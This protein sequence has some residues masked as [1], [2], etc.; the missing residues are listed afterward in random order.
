MGHSAMRVQ[1][2]CCWYCG[3]DLGTYYGRR[4][5]VCEEAECRDKYAWQFAHLDEAEARAEWRDA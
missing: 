5:E 2:H 4:V 1:H 3:T